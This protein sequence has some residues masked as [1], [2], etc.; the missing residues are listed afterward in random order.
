M[1]IPWWDYWLPFAALLGGR[2]IVVVDRPVVLHLAHRTAYSNE[3]LRNF[4]QIFVH[5]AT[6]RFNASRCP[7]D[8]IADLMPRIQ[9]IA[10]PGLNDNQLRQ[11]GGAFGRRFMAGIRMNAQEWR[12]ARQGC[13]DAPGIPIEIFARA[14]KRIAAGRALRTVRTLCANGEISEIGPELIA[15][16]EEISDDLGVLLALAEV[17]FYRKDFTATHGLISKAMTLEPNAPLPLYMMCNLLDATG[18]N[19]QAAICFGR[20]IKSH[21]S[22]EPAHIALA[23]LVWRAGRKQDAISCL[24]HAV[25]WHPGFFDAA[26]LRDTYREQLQ[27]P[28]RNKIWRTLNE[29]KSRLRLS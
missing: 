26:K 10:A 13:A 19:E 5:M 15:P 9:E 6:R 16:L 2:R 29:F 21:S 17:N 11:S 24:E 1:G 28:I 12:D 14:D 23:K 7:P 20:L 27:S 3:V 22:Y 18:K 25:A 4:A 8:L